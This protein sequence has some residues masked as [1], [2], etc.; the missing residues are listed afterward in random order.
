MVVNKELPVAQ[1]EYLFTINKDNEGFLS[2]F[3][4]YIQAKLKD[5]DR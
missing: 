2:E 5:S 3:E 4:Y 1:I